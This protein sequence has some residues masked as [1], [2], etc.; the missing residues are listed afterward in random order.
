MV[1]P[2]N[3]ALFEDISGDEVVTLLGCLGMA[4][5]AY[6]KGETVLA[7]G[8]PVDSIGIVVSGHVQVSRND[9]DGNRVIMADFGPGAMFAESFV[10]AGVANSPVTVS[11]TESAFDFS[12]PSCLRILSSV[13]AP[14]FSSAPAIP[15][16]R[17]LNPTAR[18]M[19]A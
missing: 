14:A 6:R 7:Q 13:P 17:V 12:A 18:K 15:A 2:G 1:L 5:K 9:Y 10:C 11:A 3:I 16:M 19:R 4:K 8:A